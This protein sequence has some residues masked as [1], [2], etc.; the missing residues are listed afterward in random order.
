[1]TTFTIDAYRGAR[2]V[3]RSVVK[4]P[5][6]WVALMKEVDSAKLANITQ[7]ED[8]SV[9]ANLVGTGVTFQVEKLN[10]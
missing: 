7:N 5:R 3:R 8:G 6:A 10:D 1:M 2:F 9:T 4:S